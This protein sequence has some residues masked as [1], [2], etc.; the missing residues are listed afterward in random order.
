LKYRQASEAARLIPRSADDFKGLSNVEAD[1]TNNA[2]IATGDADSLNSLSQLL[3]QLDQPVPELPQPKTASSEEIKQP[4]ILQMNL[5]AIDPA[6]RDAIANEMTRFASHPSPNTPALQTLPVREPLSDLM[7]MIEAH[8]G[9]KIS[10]PTVMTLSGVQAAINIAPAASPSGENGAPIDILP[11]NANTIKNQVITLMPVAHSN[12]SVSLDMKIKLDVDQE[13][14]VVQSSHGFTTI[15]PAGQA[16]AIW[17]YATRTSKG[18]PK[19]PYLLLVKITS[20]PIPSAN[21]ATSETEPRPIPGLP[22]SAKAPVVSP[23]KS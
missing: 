11:A 23:S 16:E 19:D 15:V 1:P 6:S 5:F 18:D 21:G 14:H 2:L 20:H 12:G 4:L 7:T 9:K 22:P 10:S 8:G 3:A 13:G 17:G